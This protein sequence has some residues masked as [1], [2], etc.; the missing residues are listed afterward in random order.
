MK[1]VMLLGVFAL[2]LSSLSAQTLSLEKDEVQFGNLKSNTVATS[3]MKVTNTGD[4]P[5]ILKSVVGS[6]GCTVPEFQTTPIAPGKS[7]DI[8]IKYST[9][10]VKGDFNK[11]VTITSNDP[12]SSRKIFRV[13]GKAE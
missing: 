4:K 1:K 8:V 13:K 10:E 9:G 5:L 11:S 2:G 6:C 3:K 12:V 7:T